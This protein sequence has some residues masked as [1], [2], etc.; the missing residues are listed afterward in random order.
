MQFFQEYLH[1][2]LQNLACVMQ[3]VFLLTLLSINVFT[4]E[5]SQK[6]IQRT[7]FQGICLKIRTFKVTLCPIYFLDSSESDRGSVL[8]KKAQP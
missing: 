7:W 3:T 2:Q 6:E 5:Y 8:A 1:L 4:V